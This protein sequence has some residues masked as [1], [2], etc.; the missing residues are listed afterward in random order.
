MT[1]WLPTIGPDVA[2]KLEALLRS[3]TMRQAEKELEA[4]KAKRRKAILAAMNKEMGA[5][6]QRR[7]EQ[8]AEL[9]KAGVELDKVIRVHRAASARVNHLGD[10]VMFV[11][12]A[13]LSVKESRARRA[14]ADLGLFEIEQA[15]G[16]LR[17]RVSE[18]SRDRYSRTEVREPLRLERCKADIAALEQLEFADVTPAAIH[19]QCEAALERAGP[20]V[21]SGFGV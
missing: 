21:D 9:E 13:Q 18:M 2:Q 1:R 15:I 17:Q 16:T 12:P 4:D 5:L 19:E 8:A 11:I 10:E 6:Q 20:L 7:A 3:P 14:L